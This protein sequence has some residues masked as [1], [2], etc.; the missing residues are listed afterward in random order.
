MTAQYGHSK[1][2]NAQVDGSIDPEIDQSRLFSLAPRPI[3]NP[4]EST[5]H[6]SMWTFLA[7]GRKR[8]A[9]LRFEGIQYW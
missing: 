7:I 2:N 6:R 3:A 1:I 4:P 8:S 5:I 9:T